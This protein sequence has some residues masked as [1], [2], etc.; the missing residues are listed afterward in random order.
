[1]NDRADQAKKSLKSYRDLLSQILD[2]AVEDKLIDENPAKSKRIANPST[3]EKERKA[4][5]EAQFK[6]IMKSV[7]KLENSA[8]KL[9][10]ALLIFTG[11]RKGEA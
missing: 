10:L 6:E 1:M 9:W 4:L 5:P 11:M 8:E 3:K 2:A 7:M